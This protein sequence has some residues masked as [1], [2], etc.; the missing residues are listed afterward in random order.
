MLLLLTQCPIRAAL[1]RLSAQ[2]SEEPRLEHGVDVETVQAVV[3]LLRERVQFQFL[4]RYLR[5]G[6]YVLQTVPV[7]D[8]QLALLLAQLGSDVTFHEFV[9]VQ[10]KIAVIQAMTVDVQR[11][12]PGDNRNVFG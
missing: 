12:V 10:V 8:H 1:V 3:E 2:V 7:F 5:V 4:E 9:G 6:H 11:L